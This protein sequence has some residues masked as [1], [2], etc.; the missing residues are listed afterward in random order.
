M[1]GGGGWI[2]AFLDPPCTRQF[3]TS[4]GEFYVGFE[5]PTH[6]LK[7]RLLI[8]NFGFEYEVPKIPSPRLQ[9]LMEN[10]RVVVVEKAL[11]TV[12][13]QSRFNLY[14][15]YWMYLRRS[16]DSVENGNY[17]NLCT[18]SILWEKHHI[19]SPENIRVFRK[20]WTEI[21]CHFLAIISDWSKYDI[22][23]FYF[24][25][26]Y[27]WPIETSRREKDGWVTKN[28]DRTSVKFCLVIES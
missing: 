21:L 8:E 28:Y 27:S 3:G 25:W 20:D 11:S 13:L 24:N 26:Y 17:M 23:N 2:E 12:S 7:L 22:R 9:L 5:V 16:S 10:L 6:Y 4:H 18:L 15:T 19:H 1:G 14:V